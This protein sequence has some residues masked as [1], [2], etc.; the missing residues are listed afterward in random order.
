[1]LIHLIRHA[2]AG[3]RKAWKGDDSERPLSDRGR[4]Q[5][6]AIARELDD[7]GVDT[8]WSSHFVRCAQTLEPLARRLSLAVE[9]VPELGEGGDGPAALDALLAAAARGRTVA[10]SSHG[11]VVPAIVAA[12]VERGATLDGPTAAKKGARY[13]LT[14]QDGSIARVVHVEAFD[15]R[16]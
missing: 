4:A 8:L 14:L 5:A 1:M 13:E 16:R 9:T 11:D 2:H 3:S 7:T 10:A 6:Q 12:A 15:A